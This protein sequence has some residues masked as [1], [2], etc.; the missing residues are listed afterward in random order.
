MPHFTVAHCIKE[1][2][3]ILATCRHCGRQ[4]NV[5]RQ[6]LVMKYGAD[7]KPSQ[8]LAAFQDR[9]KC[10][11]CALRGATVEFRR[12]RNPPGAYL[13]PSATRTVPSDG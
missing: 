10:T 4:A 8:D 11:D 3:A 7:F 5:D 9:L 12:K 13:P 6:A 2:I 1:D